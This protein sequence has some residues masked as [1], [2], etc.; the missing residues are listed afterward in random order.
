MCE[1]MCVFVVMNVVMSVV[2]NGRAVKE[3]VNV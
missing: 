3:V 2:V 1:L